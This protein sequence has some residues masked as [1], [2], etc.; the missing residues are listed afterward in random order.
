MSSFAKNQL[1]KYGWTEGKGLGKNE[2][3]IVDALKPKLK[4]DRIG[5]GHDGAEYNW[6]EHIYNE[7][8]NNL[9][10]KSDSTNINLTIK[11]EDAVRIATCK[12]EL[13][14]RTT[15]NNNLEFGNFIKTSILQDGKNTEEDVLARN[16]F[17]T[18]TKSEMISFLTD[19]EIF[20]A[21]GGR[22]A[23]KG[24]RHGL[25]LSGKL[26][27]IERQEQDILASQSQPSTSS[28]WVTVEIKRKKKRKHEKMDLEVVDNEILAIRFD[29]EKCPK[30]LSENS[31]LSPKLKSKKSRLKEK[32][33]LE[34]LTHKMLTSLDLSED[35]GAPE[36]KKRRK[37]HK[38][39]AKEDEQSNHNHKINETAD[40]VPRPLI[41]NFEAVVEDPACND[42]GFV[43]GDDLTE[44]QVRTCKDA[45]ILN[46]KIQKKKRKKVA[47]ARDEE[48][49]KVVRNIED[50]GLNYQC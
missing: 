50:P 24:A 2:N 40:N 12:S 44:P 47:T 46:Q 32:R 14:S 26:A 39:S 45:K 3:G 35:S 23:H 13:T 5:M 31:S 29:S 48:I 33:K 19:E 25:K 21:C 37:K 42:D 28:N 1:L 17:Q 4:F 38:K 18:T 34:D 11:E 16:N 27:R 20:K 7:A 30:D 49:R 41:E 9:E 22:T 6:W 36:E 8:S 43:S 15:K 10:V